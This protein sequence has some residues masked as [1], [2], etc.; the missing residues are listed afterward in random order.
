MDNEEQQ[1]MEKISE[2]LMGHWGGQ[3]G[4]TGV[5]LGLFDALAKSP[6]SV[7]EI[8]ETLNLDPEN[9]NRLLRGLEALCFLEKR[10]DNSFANTDMGAMLTSDHPQNL[11]SFFLLG[12]GYEYPTWVHLPELIRTGKKSGFKEEYG[13]SPYEYVEQD[14]EYAEVFDEAMTTASK[15]ES[16]VALELLGEEAFKGVSHL[17]DVA[18]GRGYLLSSLLQ[19]HTELTGEVLDLPAVVEKAGA[20]PEE[21]GVADRVSFTAGDMFNGVPEADA[22]I[23]KHNLHGW[24]DEECID[25]LNNIQDAAPTDAP[26]FSIEYVI[27][28]SPG[29]HYAKLYDIK[30]MVAAGGRQRTVDEYDAIF[31][32]AG[33]NLAGH[34]EAER[35]PISVVEG[36]TS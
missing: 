18:G 10:P 9:T 15:M 30:I 2:L 32:Q 16:A 28:D 36:H 12:R 35:L 29:P 22:Y 5:K 20:V 13:H 7:E 27:P 33:I 6:H 4:Y 8:A 34:T 24:S 14:P 23:M 26:V 17:G 25:I 19:E 21:M 3:I 31:S 11:R 1:P